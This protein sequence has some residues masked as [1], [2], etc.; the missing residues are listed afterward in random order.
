MTWLRVLV[1]RLMGLFRKGRL[2]WQLGEE[3]RAHLEMLAE[4][5]VRKGMPPEEARS[6]ARRSFGG[7]DQTKEV[8]RDQRACR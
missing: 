5:N 2:D 4:E 8:Y 7:V 3:L 6:A 1:S